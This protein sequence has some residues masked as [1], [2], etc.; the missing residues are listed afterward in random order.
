MGKCEY[1]K[2][3]IISSKLEEVTLCGTDDIYI[4]E[5]CPKCYNL[6]SDYYSPE[7]VDE[8]MKGG[9]K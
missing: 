9:S 6:L 2:K 7:L 8:M 3:N 1:C 4:L 5:V